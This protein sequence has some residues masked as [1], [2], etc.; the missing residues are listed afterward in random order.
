MSPFADETLVIRPKAEP[1]TR[2]YTEHNAYPARCFFANRERQM[3]LPA[4]S[5]PRRLAVAFIVPAF[6]FL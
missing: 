3:L 4:T 5:L 6:A 1:R 2:C